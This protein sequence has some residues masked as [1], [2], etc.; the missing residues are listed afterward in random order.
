VTD[1]TQR[2]GAVG[3]NRHPASASVTGLPAAQIGGDGLDIDR[4]PGRYAFQDGEERFPV[5]LA[6]SQKSQHSSFILSE[7]FAASGHHAP[8]IVVR[9]AQAAFL[10][11]R[12]TLERGG[13]QPTRGGSFRG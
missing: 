1:T 12:A 9:S 11:R 3:L 13:R 8:S 4:E 2:L 5:R 6:G 10:H 7:I